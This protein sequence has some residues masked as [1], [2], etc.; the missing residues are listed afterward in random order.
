MSKKPE[1]YEHPSY[2]LIQFSRGMGTSARRLFGSAL[3]SHYATIRMTVT[4]AFWEHDLHEDRYFNAGQPRLMEIEMSAA[5][6]AEL[7][8]SMNMGGGVPCTLQFFNAKHAGPGVEGNI[9][10]PPDIATEV[11]RVKA[12]FAGD[13]KE[14]IGTMQKYRKEIEQLSAKLPEKSKE[15]MRVALDVMI[16]QL[17]S[18]VPFILEQFNEASERVVT[19]AKHDIEAFAMHALQMAGLQ[20]NLAA[21]EA[22]KQL[23]TSLDTDDQNVVD[24]RKD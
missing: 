16:Q 18:N 4:R 9:E 17:S 23:S 24:Q 13:L 8:T 19:S 11:E 3:R 14:M 20:A 6:F 21:G 2:A 22:P 15:R 5:Q 1:T 7:I 10:E 12:N